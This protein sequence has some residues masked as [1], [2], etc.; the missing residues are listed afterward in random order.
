VSDE[1]RKQLRPSTD[2]TIRWMTTTDRRALAIDPLTLKTHA[3]VVF[4]SHGR[5]VQRA[6]R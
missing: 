3:V 6:T 5:S 2:A 1:A 4:S